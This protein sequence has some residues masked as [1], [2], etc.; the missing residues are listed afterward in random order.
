[1]PATPSALEIWQCQNCGNEIAVHCHVALNLSA[2]AGRELFTG[3]VT[4]DSEKDALKLL[5]KLK[6]ALSFA[7]RFEPFKLEAQHREGRLIWD[8]GLFLDFE[9]ERAEAACIRAGARATF[10]SGD[11]PRHEVLVDRQ[12]PDGRWV[13]TN[14]GRLDVPVG[15]VF[16]LAVVERSRKEPDGTFRIVESAEPVLL[17]SELASVDILHHP[18]PH[19]P[20]GYSGAITLI[21]AD[22][23]R[24]R[25]LVAQRLDG[26]SIKLST[27]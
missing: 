19:I 26:W 27:R 13:V 16:E 22:E 4:I 1:M 2:P 8:L 17:R 9:V 6:H 18:L 14:A 3:T 25:A 20:G 11:Q 12:L 24:L 5:L 10:R 7:E 21:G 15:A 23:E